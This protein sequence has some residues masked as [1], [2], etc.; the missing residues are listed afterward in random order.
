MAEIIYLDHLNKGIYALN[1]GNYT[2]AIEIFDNLIKLDKNLIDVYYNKGIAYQLL[3]QYQKAIDSFNKSLSINKNHINSII[4]KGIVYCI[5]RNFLK[6][7]EQFDIALNIDN[8]NIEALTNKSLALKE[9][10]KYEESL[11]CLDKLIEINE[12]NYFFYNTKG[13]LMVYL[14]K[15]EEA[16]K[17]FK[18]ATKK[19][20]KNYQAFYNM[21]ICYLNLKKYKESNACFEYAL[22]IKPTMI[23]ALMGKSLI[24]FEN[25]NYKNT[26]IIYNKIL[27]IDPNNDNIFFKKSLCLKKIEQFKEALIYINKAIEIN[28]SNIKYLFEKAKLLDILDKKDESI[29]IIDNIFLINNK[30]NNANI[31]FIEKLYLLKGQILLEKGNNMEANNVFDEIMKINPNNSKVYFYK[32]YIHAIGKKNYKE[33]LK[34]FLKCVSLNKT[35]YIAL[36]NIGLILLKEERF[37]ESKSYFTKAYEFNQQFF[38]SLLRLGDIFFK[39]GYYNTSMKYYDKILESEPNNELALIKKGD[40][41]LYK[42]NIKEALKYYEKI[43]E[44]NKY[45]EEALI[46]KGVCNCKLNNI[47]EGLFF[48]D[49]ILEINKE[50]Q[51]AL[52]N[53]AITLFNKEGKKKFL[54]K[55]FKNSDINCKNLFFLYTKGLF[56]FLDKNYNLAIENLDICLSKS[57]KKAHILYQRGLA[58]YEN[59]KYDLAIESFK[60]ALKENPNSTNI[61]NSKAIVLEKI[62]GDKKES[63]ELY[64]KACE[65]KPENALY[66]LNYCISLFENN[67]FDKCKEILNHIELIFKTESQMDLLGERLIKYIENSISVL[68]K[69]LNN[70]NKKHLYRPCKPIKKLENPVGLYNIDLNCYMNSVIQCL[71]HIIKFSDFFINEDFS[72][73]EKP[74]S[75][76]LKNIFKK[77]KNKNEGK[78]FNLKKFKDM[79]GEYDDSFSGSNGADAADLLNYIFSLLSSEYYDDNNLNGE[80]EPLD[81]SNENDVFRE[82]LKI[83]NQNCI[84]NIFYIYNKSTYLCKKNHVTYS[85]E[86]GSVLEFNI[87]DIKEKIQNKFKKAIKKISLNECFIFNNTISDNYESFCSKCQNYSF[88]HLKTNIY[89]TKEYLI[90]ILNYG[91]ETNINI[92][93][94][95]DE[96]INIEEFVEKKNKE[97]F[98]LVGIIFHYGDSSAYGHYVAYCR[99]KINNIF[100]NFN[101]SNVKISNFE[102][103]INDDVPYILFYTKYYCQSNNYIDY[104]LKKV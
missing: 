1:K 5:L 36:Y 53:K 98:K 82:A 66:L 46:G 85:F 11:K 40:I 9:L 17:Q 58:F 8:K 16:I 44:L 80:N 48:F 34:N 29:F 79:M 27:E 71:F 42:N 61:L 75:C 10:K 54:K 52:I 25:K 97:F 31:N 57:K 68:Y 35:N 20:N 45:N 89:M 33:A 73:E 64:K 38:K 91:K 6:G 72:Q 104:K 15:Y 100:Y 103:I 84:N 13:N 76:E 43:L 28:S 59:K 7:I 95:Y 77:L 32:G 99:N 94:I 23:E 60:E 67:Y 86:Y 30:S 63:M 19:N 4:S 62:Q 24:E 93:V 12:N 14:G 78:P 102:N 39:Q 65:S 90:I 56:F 87:L 2:K 96:Y 83:S 41:L 74:I 21:G 70:L 101:D 3:L 88:G 55:I 81:E 22:K 69:K 47:K 37:E 26:I 18:L 92:K 49:K 51:N 50:N